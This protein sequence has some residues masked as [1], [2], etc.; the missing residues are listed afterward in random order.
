MVMLQAVVGRTGDQLLTSETGEVTRYGRNQHQN[1]PHWL[2]LYTSSNMQSWQAGTHYTLL[3]LV[4]QSESQVFLFACSHLQG[5][6]F[7]TARMLEA[8]MKPVWVSSMNTCIYCNMQ[9]G[10]SSTFQLCS[11]WLWS[12]RLCYSFVFDGKPPQA[13]FDELRRR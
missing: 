2:R 10:S 8:G 9:D 12:M 5:M 11:Y 6:F 4:C 7:R 1:W 13:K 3:Q